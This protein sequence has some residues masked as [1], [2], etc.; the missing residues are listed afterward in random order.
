LAGRSGLVMVVVVMMM[1]IV[2]A[3]AM[4]ATD[5]NVELRLLNHA[6]ARGTRLLSKIRPRGG[7]SFKY[8]DS[9]RN[10]LQQIGV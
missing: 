5:S 10:R 3:A 7:G 9:V 6:L 1:V 2:M 8:R 4:T